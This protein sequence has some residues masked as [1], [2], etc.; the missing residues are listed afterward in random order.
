[1]RRQRREEAAE[2]MG[3]VTSAAKAADGDKSFI[4]ALKRCAT[5]NQTFP[6]P[7]GARAD[8]SAKALRHQKRDFPTT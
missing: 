4:A 8:R 1:M 2:K 5:Q 3:P 7:G 6:Q